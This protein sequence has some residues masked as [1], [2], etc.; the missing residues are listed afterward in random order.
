[1]IHTKSNRPHVWVTQNYVTIVK[2]NANGAYSHLDSI[3]YYERLTLYRVIHSFLTDMR[4]NMNSFV[5]FDW[6]SQL[7]SQLYGVDKW[8]KDYFEVSPEGDVVIVGEVDGKKARVAI[9]QIIQGMKDRGF[10]MP[11]LLRIENILDQRLRLINESFHHAI[12]EC[13]YKNVYRGVF[14]IKVNQQRHVVEEIVT[15]GQRFQHGLEA[16]SKAELLIALSAS[17]ENNR[18]IVCNGYKDEEFIDL[19]LGAIE[20][21]WKCFFVLESL[22][23]LAIILRRSIAQGVKPMLGVRVKLSA[24]VDGH[25]QEDSGDRSIFG[26]N[27]IQL[28]EVVEQLKEHNM[29]DCLQMLHFHLGSQIP[30]IQNIRQG[31]QEACRYYIALKNEGAAMGYMDLGGGLAVDYEGLSQ[32]DTHSKNY[33]LPEYCIDIVEAVMATL[34]PEGIDH[35]VLMSESG[36]ATVAHSSIFLFNILE[37]SDFDPVESSVFNGTEN[38]EQLTNLHHILDYINERNLQECHNDAHF[39][40]GEIRRKFNQGQTDLRTRALAENIF[41]TIMKRIQTLSHEAPNPPSQLHTLSEEFADTYYGNFSVFQSLPDTWAIKQVFPVMPIHRLC[42]KPTREAMIADLTCDCDGKLD[43]FIGN[44]KTIPLHTLNP[45]E[46]Y[47]LG[48]FL[49]GAY[50]ETLSDLHN[51]FGD[52]NVVSIRITGDDQFEFVREIHGDSI[53]DVLSYVEYDPKLLQEKFRDIVEQ[54]VRCGK[55]PVTTRRK[56]LTAFNEGLRGYTYYEHTHTR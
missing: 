4:K 10:E 27:A 18:Y 33:T 8:G 25:W 30:N 6:D 13:K 43:H 14:P 20:L 15:F 24:T 45:D 19:G 5:P 55:I 37:T 12:E 35:P 11:A 31:T 51:L 39:Y 48:V 23:E 2:P 1:M 47:I 46:E 7:S 53:A 41:L 29:L 28:I 32:C 49:V 42:E 16:G 17:A 36:R 38:N 3:S 56:I 54:A 9:S 34:D 26:L 22:S 44:K 52:S 21:G 40:R 50:Q